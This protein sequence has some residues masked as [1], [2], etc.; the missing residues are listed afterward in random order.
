MSL[1]KIKQIDGLQAALDLINQHVEAGS[2]KSSYTQAGHGFS[3]GV[4][5]TYV[6]SS[7]VL[8]DSSNSNKLGRLIIESITDENN[9]VAVQIGTINVSTW[10]KLSTLV[11][12]AF[13]VVDNTGNGTLEDHVN[14]GDPG[15]AYSN[16]VLQAL[17]TTTGH[18]LP[19]R[20]SLSPTDLIQ[21]EEF[22]QMG[23][24]AVTA[25]NYSSTAISLTFTP[26]QDSTVQVFSNGIALEE[27]Y[28]D[29]A[30]DVYFSR[31]GGLT[32]IPAK[33][34]DAGDVLY[35]NGQSAG[36]ELAA[37]D[38]FEIVYDKSNLDD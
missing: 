29:R 33:D 4:V 34:L 35:W 9:F 15:F 2:L 24:S 3:A 28:N 30:G 19:W 18:V 13:Y 20:P 6:D 8:A 7:W 10:P 26:F 22:T 1:I 16:P 37:D 38:Q 14:T 27:S 23:Y 12:G 5:I 17:T 31:D 32:A 11:P 25:G 36:Y 21:P